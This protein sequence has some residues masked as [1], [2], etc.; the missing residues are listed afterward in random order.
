MK[1]VESSYFFYSM[2][3]RASFEVRRGRADS[4]IGSS[5]ILDSA[6]AVQHGGVVAAAEKLA[7]LIEALTD[8]LAP[9][10]NRNVAGL[11]DGSPAGGAGQFGDGEP[12]VLCRASAAMVLSD[13]CSRPRWSRTQQHTIRREWVGRRRAARR[14]AQ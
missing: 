3:P 14:I 6:V 5:A 10:V 12:K 9:E 7:K 13:G 4:W 1:F 11:N 2:P 8:Q